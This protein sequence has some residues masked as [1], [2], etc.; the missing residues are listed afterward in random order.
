[1]MT[2]TYLDW[3]PVILLKIVRLPFSDA[4]SLSVKRA[5]LALHEDRLLYADWTLE[6]VERCTDLVCATGWK[7]QGDIDL[8]LRLVGQGARLIPSGTWL[9]PYSDR[10][11]AL[12]SQTQ[13]ALTRLT[14]QVDHN[15]V[16]P[17]LISTLA[18]LTQ[19]L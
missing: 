18:R 6:A 10:V 9:L 5:Y 11:F 19:L 8:P 13:I 15:P 4:G 3:E 12:Y 17:T 16:D 2:L 7:L 14:E 1:M